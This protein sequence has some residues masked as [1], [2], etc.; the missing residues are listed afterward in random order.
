MVKED[1][2]TVFTRTQ[3]GAHPERCVS[4]LNTHIF[5]FNV[6]NPSMARS[7]TG[8]LPGNSNKTTNWM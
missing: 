6:F 7:P 8:I 3:T 5:L 1:K 2:N 4:G